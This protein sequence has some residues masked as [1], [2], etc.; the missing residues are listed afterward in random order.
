[1]NQRSHTQLMSFE[2]L[3]GVFIGLFAAVV[4]MN[5]ELRSLGV[6]TASIVAI[7]IGRRFEGPFFQRIGIAF[8]AI[9]LLLFSTWRPIWKSFHEDFPHVAGETVLSRII[10]FSSLCAVGLAA[11]VFLARPRREGYK[12][13]PA[14]LIAFG[15]CLIAAGLVAAAIGLLWQFQQNREMGITSSIGP[16]LLPSLPKLPQIAQSP[17]PTALLPPAR[18]EPQPAVQLQPLPTT[19]LMSGYNLSSAGSRVLAEEAFKIKDVL[20]NL[21]VFLQNNDN[22]G[23]GLAGSI[24]RALSIGGIPSSIGFGQLGGPT[25]TG[26]IILYDDPE[27]LPESA[28]KLKAALER[29]GIRATVIQRKVGSFQFFIGPDPNG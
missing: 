14:Q 18:S 13:L 22:S 27:N 24:V 20:P 9:A 25:E 28:A 26:P 5:W 8:A 7:H 23:R 2:A 1:M 12:L 17:S 29:V 11:Y 21:T 15:G 16:N 3:V 4:E 19:P 6:V 10:V